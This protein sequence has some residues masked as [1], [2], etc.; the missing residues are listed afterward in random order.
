MEATA[1]MKRVRSIPDAC[2][3]ATSHALLR[4]ESQKR[5]QG[6]RRYLDPE[7]VTCIHVVYMFCVSTLPLP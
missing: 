4:P 2:F 6:P 3:A 1:R 7:R 5:L